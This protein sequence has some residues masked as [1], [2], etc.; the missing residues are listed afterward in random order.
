MND[1][2]CW[3]KRKYVLESEVPFESGLPEYFVKSISVTSAF[4]ERNIATDLT[5][6]TMRNK[7]V[8]QDLSVDF[9]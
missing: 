2:L 5:T 3:T 4:G 6:K 1:K 8:Y 7:N 9:T